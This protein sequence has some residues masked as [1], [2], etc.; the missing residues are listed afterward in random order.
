MINTYA[1]V[2]GGILLLIGILG[3]VPAFAPDGMLFGIFMV[4]GMHNVVHLISGLLLLAV[5][6]SN[7][8][9][10]ARKVTLLF[11]A[12]YGIITLMGFLSSDNIV[13]GM[14]M[15]LADDVLHLGITASALLFGLQQRYPMY[16]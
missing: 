10:L 1:K 12:I 3:F 5:G 8:W 2:M 11:A 16:R 14:R 7:N 9:D 13:M 4:D 6:L 15:N